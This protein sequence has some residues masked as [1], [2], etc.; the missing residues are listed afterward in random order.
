RDAGY[1]PAVESVR[2]RVNAMDGSLSITVGKPFILGLGE[3]T[4]DKSALELGGAILRAAPRKERGRGLLGSMAVDARRAEPAPAPTKPGLWRELGKK[5]V[6][7]DQG[8]REQKQE[9]DREYRAATRR[10]WANQSVHDW[11]E[12]RDKDNETFRLLHP[13]HDQ[14][15]AF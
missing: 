13:Y 15:K 11:L 1:D 6:P 8:P 2:V 7:F 4:I 10:I 14:L 5:S 3:S 9:A 12:T